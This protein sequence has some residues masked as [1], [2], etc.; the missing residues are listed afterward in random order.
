MI[1]TL[2]PV[3]KP[4]AYHAVALAGSQLPSRS[5]AAASAPKHWFVLAA[6]GAQYA[7]MWWL[8]HASDMR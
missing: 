2:M 1:N 3:V 6:A 7:L 8:G 5:N 4:E